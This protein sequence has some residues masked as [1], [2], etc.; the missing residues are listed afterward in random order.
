MLQVKPGLAGLWQ[1]SGRNRLTY[2][3]RRSLDLQ[4]VRSRSLRMYLKILLGIIPEV[5]TGKNSW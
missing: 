1:V 5:L 4:F 3:Q 2:P